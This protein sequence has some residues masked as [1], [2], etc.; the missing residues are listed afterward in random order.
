MGRLSAST[1]DVFLVPTDEGRYGVG[2][3]AAEYRRQLLYLVVFEE[4]VTD[5]EDV[6]G[7]I[8]IVGRGEVAF[9]SLSFDSMIYAGMWPLVANVQVSGNVKLPAYRVVERVGDEACVVVEDALGERSRPATKDEA[10][11][12]PGFTSRAP[13]RFK[14][15]LRA[16]LGLD[17][18][19][20]DFDQLRPE[21]II[22]SEAI[23]GAEE[24]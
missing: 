21:N 20:A 18:W 12:L 4:V 2:Q 3:V 17:E 5:P 24:R 7:I 22:T 16:K 19:D 8:E 10:K 14:K 9:L 13:I 15:A 1:G 6:D 23:F 11:N